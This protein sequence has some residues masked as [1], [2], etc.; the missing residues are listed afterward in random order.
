MGV[1]HGVSRA[2]GSVDLVPTIRITSDAVMIDRKLLDAARLDVAE[3][4]LLLLL[5]R[6]TVV[7]LLLEV[8][9]LG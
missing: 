2:L 1:S 3:R 7:G 4:R 5:G 6:G 9:F 8:G